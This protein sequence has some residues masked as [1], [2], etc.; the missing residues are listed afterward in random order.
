MGRRLVVLMVAICVGACSSAYR[1]DSAVSTAEAS[2]QLAG[3]WCKRLDECD[4]AKFAGTWAN[5]SEC[6]DA[7]VRDGKGAK[8]EPMQA[9][10]V[11]ACTKTIARTS[12]DAIQEKV[13]CS[14]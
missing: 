7:F 5:E 14:S 12:C 2:Q 9:S 3:A 6:V 4:R 13:D 11:D 10:Q 1:D 8:L